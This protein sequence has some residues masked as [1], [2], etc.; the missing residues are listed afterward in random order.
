M[1]YLIDIPDGNCAENIERLKQMRLFVL[2]RAKKD[3]KGIFLRKGWY[4]RLMLINE[5]LKHGEPYVKGESKNYEPRKLDSI[6]P[7]GMKL[8]GKIYIKIY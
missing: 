8:K 1:F 7:R 6:I 4:S 2:K 5:R 3:S